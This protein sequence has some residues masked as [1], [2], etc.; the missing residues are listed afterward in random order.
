M[1]FWANIPSFTP[2]K[3]KRRAKIKVLQQIVVLLVTLV[4]LIGVSSSY[5][6][7]HD[8]NTAVE[9]ADT[10]DDQQDEGRSAEISIATFK[11]IINFVQ[12]DL[13]FESYLIQELIQV[14][15]I[16][17]FQELET[18]TYCS[19]YFEKLIGL[20]ISPNAP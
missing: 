7:Q 4:T 8:L 1:D 20:I 17:H 6:V 11:A 5:A 15:T 9:V 12:I 10:A 19:G 3:M 13:H 14:D 2:R 16:I 18:P